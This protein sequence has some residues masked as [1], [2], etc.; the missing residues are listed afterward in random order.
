MRFRRPK[1][2]MTTDVSKMYREVIIPED[3]RDLHRFLWREDRVQ[4]IHEYRMTRVPN[5]TINIRYF[6]LVVCSALNM[7][8]RRNVLDH[9]QEY[10]Q[11]AK[12][13]HGVALYVDDGLVAV[14]G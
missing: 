3:Q 10:P 4:P 13:A 14:L 12:V 8:L 5:D 7:A 11:A 9:Q 6:G 2:A 1:V